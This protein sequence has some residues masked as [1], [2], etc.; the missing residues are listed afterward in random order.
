M[1]NDPGGQPGNLN[2]LGRLLLDQ[3]VPDLMHTHSVPGVAVGVTLGDAQASYTYGVTSIEAPVAVTDR[4]LF[5]IGSTA[6]TATAA[7]AAMLSS[8]GLC[9][10]DGP[11]AAYLPEFR[12]ADPEASGRV[13]LVHLLTHTGGWS[14]DA[15]QDT[16]D[17]DD[18]LASF[19]GQLAALQQVT[20]PGGHWSYSNSGFMLVGRIIEAITG[21]RYED[22]VAARIL[23]PLG[24][25]D[26][27]FF[28]K[29]VMT[30]RFAV[31]HLGSEGDIAV[32]RPWPIPRCA[33]PAG[34]LASSVRDQVTYMRWHLGTSTGPAVLPKPVR[35]MR[36]PL[37]D[38]GPGQSIGLSWFLRQL[39][40]MQTV[41]HGG[42]THGQSSAFC[43]VPDAGLGVTVLTNAG[44]GARLHEQVVDAL[45]KE[46]LGSVIDRP[47]PLLQQPDVASL[48]HWCGDFANDTDAASITPADGNL[49]L[50]YSGDAANGL[51]PL[52]VAGPDVLVVSSGA[53]E[54]MEIQLI[55]V[56]SG[57]WVSGVRFRGR[58]FARKS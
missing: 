57:P 6:K 43:L 26:S 29:D 7:V 47:R 21:Q 41:E 9:S 32:A 13:A 14:G 33:N 24:M 53:R 5:Q 19:V 2:E 42:D 38:A 8:E 3:L 50:R 52:A 15:F 40:G 20:D 36:E 46:L 39:S 37:V 35:A 10:L 54:G 58:L 51:M 48:T 16:G 17:G 12:L 23:A 27:F 55:D 28:P 31:G 44:T 45:T 30:R 1:T 25:D 49:C 11:V 22:V 18:A 34:G 4:T 56:P